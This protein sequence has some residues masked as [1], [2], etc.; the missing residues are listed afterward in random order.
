M[1]TNKHIN[2]KHCSYEHDGHFHVALQTLLLFAQNLMSEFLFLV[3]FGIFL[4]SILRTSR[5][6]L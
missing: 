2:H 4:C 1:F 5:V 6:S 3:T